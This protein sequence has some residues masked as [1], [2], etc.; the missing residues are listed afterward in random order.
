MQPAAPKGAVQVIHE[1]GVFALPLA[2]V[3]DIAAEKARLGKEIDKARKEI[4]VI[5]KKMANPNFV[6]K[7]PVEIVEENRERRVA[8]SARIEKLAAALTQ[9]SEA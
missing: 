9:I 5:D 2:G 4:E 1:G 8:F 6:E 7:A 3:I